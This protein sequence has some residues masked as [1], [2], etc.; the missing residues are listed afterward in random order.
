MTPVYSRKLR[1]MYQAGAQ[2]SE[3]WIGIGRPRASPCVPA[4]DRTRQRLRSNDDCRAT[5]PE[6]TEAV[7]VDLAIII[8]EIL[9]V[10]RKEHPSVPPD[11]APSE[12]ENCASIFG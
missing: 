1:S 12:L 2:N 11:I 9:Y 5:S 7:G 10:C 8:R 6:Y 3:P 4:P